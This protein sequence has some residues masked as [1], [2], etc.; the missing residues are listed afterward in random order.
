MFCVL[1]AGSSDKICRPSG[2]VRGGSNHIAGP[3]VDVFGLTLCIDGSK[4]SI[5]V[6]RGMWWLWCV[7]R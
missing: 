1:C 7:F 4:G 6:L 2:C 3:S 5:G